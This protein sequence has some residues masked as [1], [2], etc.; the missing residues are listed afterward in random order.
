MSSLPS[1]GVD[2]FIPP[3]LNAMIGDLF[4]PIIIARTVSCAISY[5]IDQRVFRACDGLVV[6]AARYY[7]W[8]TVITLLTYISLTT[9][10]NAGMPLWAAPIGV[11]PSFF[12]LNYL[13]QS[14]LVFDT[15]GTLRCNVSRP[16]SRITGLLASGRAHL[17]AVV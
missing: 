13:S 6:T 10:T 3:I 12:I 14:Y 16:G 2:Y 17:T 15:V 7:V 11:N 1:T 4:T 8:G 5:L 9:L